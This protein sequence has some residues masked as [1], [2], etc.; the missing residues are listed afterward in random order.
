MKLISI[1][2]LLLCISG[3]A[4]L[5]FDI[6]WLM[7]REYTLISALFIITTIV[8]SLMWGIVCSISALFSSQEFSNAHWKQSK[9]NKI[10]SVTLDMVDKKQ[11]KKDKK[12]RGR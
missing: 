9:K 3:I 7:Y 1:I 10:H 4:L 5:G 8:V 6:W 11:V 12:R 2:F